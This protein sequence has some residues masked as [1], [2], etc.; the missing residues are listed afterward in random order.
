MTGSGRTLHPQTGVPR[1]EA[2]TSNKSERSD[3]K[4]TPPQAEHP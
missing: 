3:A 2:H 4:V 1:S